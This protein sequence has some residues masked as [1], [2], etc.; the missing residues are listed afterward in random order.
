LQ[1]CNTISSYFTNRV[2]GV[3]TSELASTVVDRMLE[4][5]SGKIKDNAIDTVKPALEFT[6]I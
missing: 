3:M 6:S 5:R 4:S 2:V 1:I